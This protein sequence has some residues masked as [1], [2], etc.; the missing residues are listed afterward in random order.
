MNL[1]LSHITVIVTQKCNL[2]CQGCYVNTDAPGEWDIEAFEESIL[3]PFVSLGGKSIGFSGGEPMLYRGLVEGIRLAK[4]YHLYVSLVTNGTL[5]NHET[6]RML[7]SLGVDSLQIS[8]DS[9]ETSYNDSI[10]GAG[11]KEKVLAAVKCAVSA[12]LATN[13]VAVPNQSL[14]RCFDSYVN[15]ARQLGIRSIYLRR[16]IERMKPEEQPQEISLNKEFLRRIKEAHA[17]YPDIRISSGD[18][19]FN[20]L[21]YDTE[22][23]E[24]ILLFS[25]CSAGITSLA[26]WPDGALTPCTRLYAPVGNV[27]V[28]GLEQSWLHSEL[29]NRLRDRESLEGCGECV[30]R[31]VCGGCRASAFVQ[32]ENVFGCDPLCFK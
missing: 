30:F 19:L 18:P 25:G 26:V 32:T 24:T 29:L 4:K 21:E 7:A 23:K 28:E 15:E 17:K 11:N 13:L 22:G 20:I 5:L 27:F 31:F 8:L 2:S 10:R 9:S 1:P 3:K 6:A 14:L 12:G 16:R